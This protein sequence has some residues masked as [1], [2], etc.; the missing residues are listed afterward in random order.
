MSDT[1]DELND[2]RNLVEGQDEDSD[3]EEDQDSRRSRRRNKYTF[4]SDSKRFKYLPA[5]CQPENISRNEKICLV[6]G[7]I[8]VVVIIVVFIAVAVTASPATGK[9]NN[10]NG[11][12]QDT[13]DNETNVKW[14][15]VRLQSTIIPI[16]YSINLSVDLDSFQV[17]GSVLVDCSV[18]SNVDYVAIH[19]KD[20][21]VTPNSHRLTRDNK[22][23]AHNQVWYRKNDFFIFNLSQPLS[24]GPVAISMRFNYS[25]RTDLAG[26][27]R[28]SYQTAERT[29]RYLATTQFE[30][31]DARRA[32]PCFDEPAMKANFTMQIRHHNSYS[33]WFNMP[34]TERSGADSAGFV[35]TKFQT[36]VK[37]SSYLVAFIVSDFECRSGAIAS[38]SGKQVAVRTLISWFCF[39]FLCSHNP[40]PQVVSKIFRL[41]LFLIV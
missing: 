13:K 34:R 22:P 18:T 3:E 36:S 11:D 5:W 40:H 27:Y 7:L 23:I 2:R 37:M 24:P 39:C 19:V 26:F 6:A 15:D 28:S 31:T 32:F 17:T 12:A 30:P 14:S 8:A 10:E 41:N 1:G 29:T 20:M 35:T 25:L 9:D 33:A 38:T 4:Q 16:H 21:D